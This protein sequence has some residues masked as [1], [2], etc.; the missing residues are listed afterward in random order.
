MN[1]EK[2]IFTNVVGDFATGWGR[3]ILPLLKSGHQLVL[4][5]EPENPYDNNA[6]AVYVL[7]EGP[8]R[9]L[10]KNARPG[11]PLDDGTLLQPIERLGYIPRAAAFLLRGRTL[12][13]AEKN[14]QNKTSITV[15]YLALIFAAFVTFSSPASAEQITEAQ[16]KT[17]RNFVALRLGIRD[18]P[19]PAVTQDPERYTQAV[20]KGKNAQAAYRFGTIFMPAYFHAP[21]DMPHLVHEMTHWAQDYANWHYPCH[22]AKEREAYE[23]Q[24]AYARKFSLPNTTVTEE[25]ISQKSACD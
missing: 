21:E 19:I 11:I 10:I 9:G 22:A 5:R 4:K 13:G 25:F 23:A 8:L 20:R 18:L 14:P 24:N 12:V 16:I 6:I 7:T 2:T 3:I 15:K 1:N 17:A